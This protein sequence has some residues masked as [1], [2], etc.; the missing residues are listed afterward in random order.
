MRS[1]RAHISGLFTKACVEGF[2]AVWHYVG[3][4]DGDIQ[5]QVR[6]WPGTELRKCVWY[7]HFFTWAVMDSEVISL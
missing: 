7:D 2:F 5:W 6:A 1:A 4:M 3:M